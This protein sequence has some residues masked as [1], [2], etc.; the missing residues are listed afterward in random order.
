M[1]RGVQATVNVVPAPAVAGDFASNNP[2][3]TALAGP[4]GYVAGAL[5][6]IVG[7]FCWASPPL[8]PNNAPQVANSFG[9][10]PVLGLIGREQQGIITTFLAD[11]S[12]VVNPGFMVTPYTGGDFWV[13]NDGSTSALLGTKAYADLSTGK[14]AFAATGSP[15]TATST[16]SSVAAG[17]GCSFLNDSRTS[18]SPWP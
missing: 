8:D 3:Y 14:V 18:F 5:G 4:G 11:A 12:M 15:S 1:S 13:Q 10:G 6:A 17:S 9:S 2:R 16:S 7:H